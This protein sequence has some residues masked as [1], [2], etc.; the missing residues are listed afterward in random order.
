MTI[1]R[2]EIRRSDGGI[3]TDTEITVC[4]EDDAEIRRVTLINRSGSSMTLEITSYAELSLAPHGAD[5]MHPAF[6]NLF[7]RTEAVE[8]EG[9][10]FGDATGR[11]RLDNL[12]GSFS[13]VLTEGQFG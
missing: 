12:L 1:D 11:D 2:V 13:G 4:P 6:H 8:D 5:V 3:E 9:Y 7:V 10:L